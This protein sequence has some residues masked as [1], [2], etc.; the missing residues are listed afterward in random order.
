MGNYRRIRSTRLNSSG[1]HMRAT[2]WSISTDNATA[3]KRAGGRRQYNAL[4]QAGAGLRLAQI[5]ELFKE[6]SLLAATEWGIRSEIARKFG[7]SRATIC[8][9]MQHLVRILRHGVDCDQEWQN[10]YRWWRRKNGQ[11]F[12]PRE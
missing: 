9:D 8:R 2:N 10:F 7:V 3:Y 4:H 5:A 12:G 11:K 1:W 6:Q